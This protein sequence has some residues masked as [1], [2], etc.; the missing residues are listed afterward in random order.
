MHHDLFMK[1]GV[2]EDIVLKITEMYFIKMILL[3]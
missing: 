3:K 1:I 2:M